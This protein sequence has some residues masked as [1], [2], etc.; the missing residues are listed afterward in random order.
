M[1]T[2]RNLTM[3]Q[4]N[5]TKR[6]PAV[7][8]EIGIDD[9]GIAQSVLFTFANGEQLNVML[10]VLNPIVAAYAMAHGIKQKIGDAT[11]ISR[12]PDNGR[13]ASVQDKFEAAKAVYDRLLG[14]EW[15]APREG[16]GGQG[17]LLLRAMVEFTGKPVETVKT[18]LDS[19][20]D[21]ERAALRKNAKVAAIIVRMQAEKADKS[22]D[23]DAMLSEIAK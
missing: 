2:L 10:D 12:N 13:S 14:G 17:N 15:N 20:S 11:A 22:I 16:G 3:T 8:T 1:F 23:T 5:D 6:Q 18:W 21:D 9:A 7:S 4:A 19:K